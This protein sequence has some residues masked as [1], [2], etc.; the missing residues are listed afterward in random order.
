MVENLQKKPKVRGKIRERTITTTDGKQSTY[1]EM[2]FSWYDESGERQ[3]HSKTTGLPVKGNKSRAEEMLE[4]E[5]RVLQDKLNTQVALNQAKPVSGS[6]M[7]VSDLFIEWLSYVKNRKQKPIKDSTYGGYFSIV[8]NVLVPYF[9]D[10]GT[11]LKD[12]SVDDVEEFYDEQ[13]ERVIGETVLKY[14][15]CISAAL[16]FAIKKR[17]YIS[18]SI[19]PGVDKPSTKPFRGD[20]LN[21]VELLA[22]CE[23]LKKD[24]IYC[25]LLLS[26]ILGGFYALRRSEVVGLRWDAINFDGNYFTIKHTVV[27]VNVNGKTVIKALD[28][29]KNDASYQTMPLTPELKALFIEM[30]AQ[31]DQNRILCG[32]SYN[33]VEGQYVNVDVM[34]NRINPDYLSS[35]FPKFLKKMGINKKI[36]FHDLRHSCATNLFDSG[37]KLLDVSKW[38]R[39]SSTAITERLYVHREFKDKVATANTVQWMSKLS[40]IPQIEE[41]EL[42]S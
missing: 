9:K 19:M 8:H 37:A 26:V 40:F 17:K 10:K 32:N 11:I 21:E 12:L 31:Q 23:A 27:R 7:L 6:E 4:E 16:T 3:R 18:A 34:G 22:V 25:K 30:K 41:Q 39:H 38:L 13:L 5:K 15:S 1:W 29:T 36:R 24:K 20:T 2:K 14:H 28:E 35:A 33:K 42:A